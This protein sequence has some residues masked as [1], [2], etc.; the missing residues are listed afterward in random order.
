MIY[1]PKSESKGPGWDCNV[2]AIQ[3]SHCHKGLSKS[4]D[5][6]CPVTNFDGFNKR[7]KA[8]SPA[9]HDNSTFLPTGADLK[10][11]W[12]KSAIPSRADRNCGLLLTLTGTEE[13]SEAL[14][15]QLQ[16]A[17]IT[18]CD[19]LDRHGLLLP[20]CDSKTVNE[21]VA[22]RNVENSKETPQPRAN[23]EIR[24]HIPIPESE[25]EVEDL[26]LTM[27]LVAFS[28]LCT[29]GSTMWW[30]AKPGYKTSPGCQISHGNGPL[31]A[32]LGYVGKDNFQMCPW[33]QGPIDKD[34]IMW[35]ADGSKC[36]GEWHGWDCCADHGGRV[37]CPKNYRFMC[38][39]KTCGGRLHQGGLPGDPGEEHCCLHSCEIHGG[40]RGCPFTT[41]VIP[42]NDDV[43]E[44]KVER[45]YN[46]GFPGVMTSI[47]ALQTVPKMRFMRPKTVRSNFYPNYC[48]DF[49]CVV[50]E[51][52]R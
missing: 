11:P 47:L 37:R 25:T 2:T 32:K 48:M 52:V 22:A 3:A 17:E 29:F 20:N 24:L 10:D 26:S 51:M 15:I 33:L 14:Q 19:Y 28:E 13:P 35:C 18:V 6:E 40:W 5:T 16:L 12:S 50:N 42:L 41:M 23:C 1:R 45:S 7:V 38:E 21:T 49:E 34:D 43:F 27:A 9:Y 30:K 4:G 8:E 44:D 39:A 36:N 31:L 46:L